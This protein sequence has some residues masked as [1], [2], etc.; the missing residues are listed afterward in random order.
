MHGAQLSVTAWDRRSC[1]CSSTHWVPRRH[2]HALSSHKSRVSRPCHARLC[3]QLSWH[4]PLHG[5]QP[6]FGII[7][8]MLSAA[9]AAI[10]LES[11]WWSDTPKPLQYGPVTLR[12]Y[13]HAAASVTNDQAACGA[14]RME[15]ATNLVRDADNRCKTES[16]TTRC[17][18]QLL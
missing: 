9:Q 17:C 14:S 2:M 6:D 11:A 10:M 18:Q 12:G 7:N 1:Q 8:L 16:S 15:C 5:W 4:H 13:L 3:N